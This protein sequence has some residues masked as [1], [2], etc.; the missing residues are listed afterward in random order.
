MHKVFCDRELDDVE[1]AHNLS[2]T[3]SY[4]W[5]RKNQASDTLTSENGSTFKQYFADEVNGKLDGY[6]TVDDIKQSFNYFWCLFE[7]TDKT[8]LQRIEDLEAAVAS[9]SV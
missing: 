7:D 1:V 9:I 5:L 3:V 8:I 4:I 2:N 6:Y